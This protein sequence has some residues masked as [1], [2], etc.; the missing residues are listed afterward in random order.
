VNN[1][2]TPGKKQ[3]AI[4]FC[5][6]ASSRSESMKQ[7][8]DNATTRVAGAD[9]YRS[10][11]LDVDTWVDNGY[12]RS[13]VEAYFSVIREAL[14]SDNCVTDIRFPSSSSI[15][16]LLDVEFH[17]YLNGT[18]SGQIPEASRPR[19]RKA[20]CD[21]L[22][23]KWRD[24]IAE[25][26]SKVSSRSSTLLQYQKLQG[27]YVVEYNYNYLGTGIIAYG[28]SIAALTLFAS[29]A[30]GIWTY[31]NRASSVVRASQPFFLILISAGVFVFSA[32]IIPMAMDDGH[33]SVEA[34]DKACMAIPW[35][36]AMGWSILFSALYAK[37][38]RVNLMIRNAKNFRSVHVS[39]KDVMTPFAIVFSANLILLLVWTII[40]PLYWERRPI[41]ATESYGTC[42]ANPQSEAWKVI[43]ALLG[44]LNGAALVGA[45]VE[46]WKARKISTEYG[47][48]SYI[49]LIMVSMLQ[50]V[51]VGVP[52][53]FL[54][55][56]NP[57]A[58]FFVN[59]S[60]AFV[61][62]MSVLSLLFLPKIL[63]SRSKSGSKQGDAKSSIG[64]SSQSY[65][66][67]AAVV[68]DM[69]A[70]IQNLQ[71]LLEE[72]GIDCNVYFKETGLDK[73]AL[74]TTASAPI[75]FYRGS[76]SLGRESS[77]CREPSLP[78]VAEEGDDDDSKE[79]DQIENAFRKQQAAMHR[80][81]T[82]TSISRW[83][84]KKR[85]EQSSQSSESAMIDGSTRI[86]MAGSM[87]STIGLSNHECP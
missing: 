38:R 2:T 60:M 64:D 68:E 77:R 49:G 18:V 72:A 22:T 43:L 56:E 27:V 55:H 45:N 17:D 6:Y 53:S 70:R 71:L 65:V 14:N 21:R 16:A 58:R 73:L 10:S 52:L 86:D 62:S 30:C 1:Y 39:E 13:S 78:P 40:D 20:I 31:R 85:T 36:G 35:L 26:D 69:K 11:H 51:L 8:V 37:I 66:D 61:T 12:D 19:V 33:F 54:V 7:V 57:T 32:S 34:C 29:V 23:D 59:S 63:R 82:R 80:G 75:S 87:E 84:E 50:V 42:A 24:I 76:D 9:P 81:C 83:L 28:Y 5:S 3:L 47:E 67:N 46:A 74:S 41:N 79:N 4:E 44:A 48:S 15:Y 25:F